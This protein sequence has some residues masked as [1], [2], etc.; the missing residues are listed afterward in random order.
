[1]PKKKEKT[2]WSKSMM[3]TMRTR[4]LNPTSGPMI[5]RLRRPKVGLLVQQLSPPILNPPSGIRKR[6]QNRKSRKA[7][8]PGSG[9]DPDE[10]EVEQNDESEDYRS[11]TSTRKGSRSSK[12]IIKAATS[13]NTSRKVLMSGKPV[14]HKIHAGTK[15]K[16][17][18]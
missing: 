12:G 5:L 18:S 17:K 3:L 14:S 1:M 13:S 8:T 6:Q 7:D 4:A 16:M 11:P 2:R 15:R 9:E 10:E